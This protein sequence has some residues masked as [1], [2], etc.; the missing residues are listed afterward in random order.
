MYPLDH[1]VPNESERV[2]KWMDQPNTIP[3][4]ILVYYQMGCA[5]GFVVIHNQGG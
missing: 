2:P 3:S 4:F 5:G 1:V